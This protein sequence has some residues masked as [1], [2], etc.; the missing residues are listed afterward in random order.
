MTTEEQSRFFHVPAHNLGASV[1]LLEADAVFIVAARE[2]VPR[3]LALV[4]VADRLAKTLLEEHECANCRAI[5][6]PFLDGQDLRHGACPA[7]V[8]IVNDALRAYEEARK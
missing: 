7:V 3:L 1:E 5:H 4:E 8:T 6:H 2:A